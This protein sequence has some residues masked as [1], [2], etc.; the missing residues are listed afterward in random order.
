[1]LGF[2][3]KNKSKEEINKE[4]PS[5]EELKLCQEMFY[6]FEIAKQ[7][8][9]SKVEMW[10]KCLSAYN[11]DYFK[12]MNLPDYKSDEI[13]NFIFSTIETIKPIMTD[14]DPKILILPKTPQGAD[15]I[16]KL[17]NAFDYEWVRAKMGR[18]LPQAITIALQIGTAIIGIFWDGSDEN[19][20]GNVKPTLINPFNFYPDPMATCVEDA[21]YIIYATYK[22]VND[23]KVKYP[24]KSNLLSGGTIN[25]S[26]LVSSGIDTSNVRNQVLVLE[27][28]LRDYTTIETEEEIDGEKKK[29][30]KR[31][32]PKGRVI[33][34][35]PELNVILEDKK[36]PYD[37]G[38]FPFK[39]IKCYDIPFEFWGK[40]EIEQLLSPQQYINEL[41]NQI[42]DNAKLTANMPWVIDKNSGIGRGQLTNRPGLIIRKNPGTEVKRLVPPPMPNYVAEI[43]STLKRDIEVISGIH[44][45]T[46]G[47]KPGSISAASAILALQE[48]AQARIRLK[49]RAMEYSLS[50]IGQI[51]FSRMR[52]F[53]V[54]D[55]WVRFE[56]EEG[57]YQFTTITQA[58]LSADIDFAIVGG[59]TMPQNKNAMLDLIIRLAQTPAEDGLPMVDR[60]TVLTYTSIA[61]KKKILNHFRDIN[62]RRAQFA[63]Q[64]AQKAEQQMLMQMQIE[65]EKEQAKLDM[66]KEIAMLKEAGKVGSQIM[67]K[68]AN[69]NQSAENITDE[70][71]AQVI[72]LILTDPQMLQM[73][74]QAVTQQQGG[75]T[76]SV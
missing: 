8:K 19:G 73:I 4:Q 75:V 1:M 27:C 38:Q 11:S 22:H 48:A 35:C 70:Q 57:N 53:W 3:K 33:T 64:D 24:D 39:L 12:Q 15:N 74:I 56:D 54:T 59:S 23:L 31:K 30:K 34:C 17:Q 55:R 18:L 14:N 2:D 71:I 47:E 10:N 26:E 62:N 5:E 46:R 58:D 7:A 49:V 52:Q 40:G 42:I 21:E 61:D 65:A 44:D 36:S 29:V 76:Q 69:K 43:V 16:D 28:W 60:E 50:E 51:W 32:Y 20:I 63:Q 45:V 41:M 25:Y 68:E 72:Q 66:Q 37:D 13:S 9:S 67:S 6:K